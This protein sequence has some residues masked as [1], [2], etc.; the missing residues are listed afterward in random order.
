MMLCNVRESCVWCLRWFHSKWHLSM[1]KTAILQTNGLI[2]S[3]L[4]R[5]GSKERF[6]STKFSLGTTDS[7]SFQSRHSEVKVQGMPFLLG[8]DSSTVKLPSK[9]NIKI[10]ALKN[11][12]PGKKSTLQTEMVNPKPFKE[13]TSSL[14]A[15]CHNIH[16]QFFPS[17]ILLISL[18]PAGCCPFAQAAPQEHGAGCASPYLFSPEKGKSIH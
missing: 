9:E 1:G 13:A 14:Q 12:K 7:Q 17:E 16:P 6:S 3:A 8:A 11:D 2:L 4:A 15:A 10:S 5:E 18:E